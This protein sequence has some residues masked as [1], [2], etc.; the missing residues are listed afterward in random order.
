M[1]GPRALQESTP[2]HQSQD[3]VALVKTLGWALSCQRMA[4]RAL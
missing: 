4:A 2:A 3:A 1:R